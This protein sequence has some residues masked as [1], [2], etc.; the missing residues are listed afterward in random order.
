M[1]LC[2]NVWGVPDCGKSVHR[3]FPSASLPPHGPGILLPSPTGTALHPSGAALC[4]SA[5]WEALACPQS[6]GTP[7]P[8][9]L[10]GLGTAGKEQG[11]VVCV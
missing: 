1:I 7:W 6:R 2:L 3:G 5:L 11:E 8:Q 4:S 9:G 10:P